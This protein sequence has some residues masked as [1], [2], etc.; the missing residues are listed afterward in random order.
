[1]LISFGINLMTFSQKFMRRK[2]IRNW[3]DLHEISISTS[4]DWSVPRR[5]KIWILIMYEM[6]KQKMMINEKTNKQ[7]RVINLQLDW[8]EKVR[9]FSLR[10]NNKLNR[11]L[12]IQLMIL[13]LSNQINKI[14]K[15]N[16]FNINFE[17]S[18]MVLYYIFMHIYS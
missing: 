16:I 5:L 18:Y 11:R 3:M 6:K 1:M 17:I 12:K 9:I 8:L 10:L 2:F 15:F 14:N 7:I 4:Q 13:K